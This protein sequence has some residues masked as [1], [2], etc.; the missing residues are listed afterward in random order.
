MSNLVKKL[1]AQFEKNGDSPSIS[2]C[3]VIVDDDP[4]S[5]EVLTAIVQDLGE[6]LNVQSFDNP[7]DALKW[8]C[9]NK[10]N[11]IITDY[12]MPHKNGVEFIKAIKQ[13]PACQNTPIMMI[14][15][16]SEKSIR[17]EALDAGAVAFLT[18]PVDHIECKT[19][20]RNLLQ[21]N[22]QQEIIE[23]RAEWLARKVNQ[24]TRDIVE[25]E[26]ETLLRLSRA[27]EYRDQ[28]TGNH[29]IR[30]AKYARLIAEKLG[31]DR[32]HCLDIEYAAPMH[33]IGKIG[34]PDHILLK[35]GLFNDEERAFMQ[36]HS[37]IGFDILSNSRSK[38]IRLGAVIALYH[39]EKFD[40]SGYPEGL[41][42]ESIPLE[43]RIVAVADVYDALTSE[44]PYKKP[45][46]HEATIELIAS[47]SGKHFDPKCVDAFLDSIDEVLEI[48]KTYRD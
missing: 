11:L 24:A 16:D 15:G 35:P 33:D 26:K 38:Y 14:T 20:C 47:E 12:H 13:N 9:S 6:G 23:Q 46:T 37:R 21:L 40:G 25:R 44:R 36:N 19:S 22:E 39:H 1:E 3:I 7:L 31:L 45:W 4:V 27:G 2:K 18:R 32:E 41:S 29:V 30:M 17:Y 43:A 5:K 28:E 48:S 8:I 42:G 34:I 10:V